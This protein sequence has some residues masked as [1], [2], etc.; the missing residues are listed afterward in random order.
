MYFRNGLPFSVLT[1]TLK[2]QLNDIILVAFMASDA[3][4]LTDTNL[5]LPKMADTDISYIII[6][7]T[8]QKSQRL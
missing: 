5:I 4:H 3:Y 1:P 7:Y 2:K 6:C 8:V